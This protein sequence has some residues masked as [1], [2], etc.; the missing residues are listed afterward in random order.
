MGKRIGKRLAG[1]NPEKPP[2]VKKEK[3]QSRLTGLQKFLLVIC[4][5]LAI[6]L[7]GVL[8]WKNTFV[9]PELKDGIWNVRLLSTLENRKGS[10]A[11]S[12]A[13]L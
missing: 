4:I 2:K 6:A 5:L 1:S 3:K 8:V 11:T 12:A 13:P 7:A 9:R 10:R